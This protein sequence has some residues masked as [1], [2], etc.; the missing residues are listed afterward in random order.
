M[1]YDHE[2]AGQITDDELHRMLI[3]PLPHGVL[4]T[5]IMD[6]CHSGTSMDLPF[7]HVLDTEESE[8]DFDGFVEKELL[9][10]DNHDP[11]IT[12]LGGGY[13][14]TKHR[15]TMKARAKRKNAAVKSNKKYDNT[16]DA[17]VVMISGCLDEQTSVGTQA[18]GAMV[19]AFTK[20]IESSNGDITYRDLVL[21]MRDVLKRQNYAQIPQLST[22][23]P[24]NLD[25]KLL[26]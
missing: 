9:F 21:Q 14:P 26:I 6:C 11:T 10:N 7:V 5:C 16:S 3:E 1:P 12:Q 17:S 22:A 19:L 8:R 18:G 25:S 4:L 24:F 2:R 15:Y 13:K 20:V 23:R